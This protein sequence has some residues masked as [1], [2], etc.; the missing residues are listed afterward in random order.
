MSPSAVALLINSRSIPTVNM[1]RRLS[2]QS[3][4]EA[5]FFCKWLFDDEEYERTLFG[6]SK[7]DYKSPYK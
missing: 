1:K 4:R 3:A 6:Y 2:E 7:R 5:V